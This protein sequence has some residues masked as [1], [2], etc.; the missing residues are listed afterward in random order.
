VPRT[1]DLGEGQRINTPMLTSTLS[2]VLLNF[3][4]LVSDRCYSPITSWM[5]GC[6]HGWIG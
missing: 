5:D 2:V 4:S 3:I 1:S 6:M